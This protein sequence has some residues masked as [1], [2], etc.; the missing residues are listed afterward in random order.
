MI[1]RSRRC[2]RFA[3]TLTGVALAT[4]GLLWAGP[5]AAQGQ[6]RVAADDL[7]GGESN[8]DTGLIHGT[9]EYIKNNSYI[10]IG[11]H[12]MDYTGSSSNLSVINATGL[13]ATA[14]GPGDS[15]LQNTGAGMGDKAFAGATL[16][17]YIPGT[18]HH[19]AF[20]V[21]L[22]PPL[23]L[24]VEVRDRAADESLAPYIFENGDKLATGIQ[25]I[26]KTVGTAK[27]LPPNFT[28]VYRPWVDTLIQPYIGIGAMYMYTYDIDVTNDVLTQNGNEPTLYLSKPVAC[29]GQLGLDIMLPNNFFLNADVRY[30]GCAEIVNELSDVEVSAPKLPSNPPAQIDVIR[31]V[32][33]FEALIYSVNIGFRF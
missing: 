32:V 25:P 26:G 18:G 21:M 33:E 17:L 27:A 23:E 24:T 5:A 8:G 9:I 10:S 20:E 4:A 13:A 1:N 29:V 15:E 2:V 19:L 12:Y 22:A 14:F 28:I 31:S 6:M 11:P 16:G 30:V 7:P 3:A